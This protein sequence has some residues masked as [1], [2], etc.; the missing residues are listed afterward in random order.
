MIRFKVSDLVG[1]ENLGNQV[2]IFIS[3]DFRLRLNLYDGQVFPVVVDKSVEL[4]NDF[5]KKFKSNDETK[6]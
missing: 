1:Y 4:V 2:N 3:S 5:I 6:Q